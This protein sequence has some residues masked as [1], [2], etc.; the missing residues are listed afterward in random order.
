MEKI[1]DA[2]LNLIRDGV[3]FT[4]SAI[5]VISNASPYRANRTYQGLYRRASKLSE[6]GR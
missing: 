6:R 5:I 2:I 3:V 1:N 4:T